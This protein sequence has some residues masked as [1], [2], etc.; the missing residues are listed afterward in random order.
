MR[1]EELKFFFLDRITFTQLGYPMRLGF[2]VLKPSG[3]QIRCITSFHINLEKSHFLK[4]AGFSSHA[5]VI[6]IAYTRTSPT[7]VSF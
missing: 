1:I 5:K 4:K 2:I 3:A 6:E 7:T